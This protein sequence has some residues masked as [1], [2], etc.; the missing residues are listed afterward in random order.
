MAYLNEK[1]A[2]PKRGGYMT[3]FLAMSERWGSFFGGRGPNC[4]STK[5]KDDILTA[6]VK[7]V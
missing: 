3:P 2:A 6:S 5:T 1:K 7:I 4:A